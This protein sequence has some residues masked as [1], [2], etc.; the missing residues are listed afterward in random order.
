MIALLNNVFTPNEIKYLI[1]IS[2]NG[3]DFKPS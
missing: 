2:F 1:A 3:T